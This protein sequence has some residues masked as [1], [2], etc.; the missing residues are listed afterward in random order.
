M[1]RFYFCLMLVA[2]IVGCEDGADFVAEKNRMI[3]SDS[4]AVYDSLKEVTLWIPS[5]QDTDRA[6]T[7]VY[8]YLRN[9]ASGHRII[10]PLKEDVRLILNN[11]GK[12]AVQFIGI[13]RNGEKTILCNF[14]PAD[15]IP[16]LSKWKTERIIVRDGG[17]WYWN[18]EYDCEEQTCSQLHINGES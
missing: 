7:A 14:L 15:E 17:C 1:K 11:K 13:M 9:R 3:I 2:A 4:F 10:D 6:L 5:E 18:I 8:F 12:Y 16:R